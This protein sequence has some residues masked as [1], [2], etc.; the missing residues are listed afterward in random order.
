MGVPHPPSPSGSG[1]AYIMISF[2]LLQLRNETLWTPSKSY[3]SGEI[4]T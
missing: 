2:L 3:H 1:P 4:M